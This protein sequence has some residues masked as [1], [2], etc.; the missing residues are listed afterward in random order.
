LTDRLD[1][2]FEAKELIK[3]IDERTARAKCSA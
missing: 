3:R 1:E 2:A